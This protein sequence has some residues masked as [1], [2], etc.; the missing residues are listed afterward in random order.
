[1]RLGVF[2]EGRSDKG[3]I[4][5]LVRKVP[6]QTSTALE[7]RE[8]GNGVRSFDIIRRNL[9]ALLSLHGDVSKVIVCADLH[10]D[11][12]KKREIVST[13][14]AL[15]SAALSVPVKYVKVL[16]AIEGWLLA[17]RDA[18]KT[19]LGPNSR[20]GMIPAELES[21]CDQVQILEEVFRR[22]NKQYVKAKWAPIIAGH[23]KVNPVA[24]QMSSFRELLDALRDP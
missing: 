7:F 15:H 12:V 9:E 14:F 21:R 13:E 24:A 22:N 20:L 1:M 11:P 5:A 23:A 10:S 6:G 3:V 19:A 4:G 2:V 18:L 16:H 17:D 8:L